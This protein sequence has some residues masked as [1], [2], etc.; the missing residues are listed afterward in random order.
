MK[1]SFLGICIFYFAWVGASFSARAH[2]TQPVALI[3]RG[4]GV[5]AGCAEG[6]GDILT[7]MNFKVEYITPEQMT[8]EVFKRADLYAQPGGSDRVQ[9]TLEKLSAE[10]IKALQ[11]FVHDG[12]RFLGV[13]AGAYLAGSAVLDQGQVIKGFGLVPIY[14]EDEIKDPQPKV[15]E[16]E[17][18]GDGTLT[19]RNVYFQDG[20][21]LSVTNVP[22]GKVWAFYKNTSDVAAMTSRYGS[23]HVGLIGPHLEADSSWFTDDHLDSPATLSQDLFRQFVAALMGP[24]L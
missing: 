24:S 6:I 3:F 15:I 22:Q 17:W 4:P 12:G 11:N 5:C 20:P 1:F 7:T 23:G 13:C 8:P 16:I 9:D 19:E 18:T 10:N 14:I 21:K 2:T